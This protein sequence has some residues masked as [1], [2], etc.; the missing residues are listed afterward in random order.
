M[1]QS[2]YHN[3]KYVKYTAHFLKVKINITKSLKFENIIDIIGIYLPNNQIM[4]SNKIK[5][6]F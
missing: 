4:Q 2:C 5:I 3:K 1:Q 6:H